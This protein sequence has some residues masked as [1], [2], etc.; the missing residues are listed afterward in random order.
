[1][2]V[3]HATG[4][5]FPDSSGGT[6]V[7]VDALARNLLA[8]GFD[9]SVAAATDGEAT[10]YR[11]NGV[12]VH[13]FPAGEPTRAEIVGALPSPR[14]AEF[15][16]TLRRLKADV[17][18]QHSWSRGCGLAHLR[19][20]KAL[21]LKTVVTVH[22]ATLVC[23]RGTMMLDGASPCDGLVEVA[24]CSECWGPTRGIPRALARWQGQ[25]SK[26]AATLG[27]WLPSASRLRTALLTPALVERRRDD[28]AELGRQADRIVAVCR[29]LYDALARNGV[30]REKLVYCPQGIDVPG[31]V[32]LRARGA[33]RPGAAVRIGF[34]GRCDGAKGIHVLVDAVRRLPAETRVELVIHALPFDAA[35]ARELRDRAG[36]DARIRFA[37]PI[38]RTRLLDELTTFDVLAVPSLALETGPLV[39][40]E[41][42]AAG[43]PVLGSNL[44]G[45]AELVDRERGELLPAGDVEAWSR[46]VA[47]LAV[48]PP[49]VRW[50]SIAPP[51]RSSATIAAEMADVYVQLAL[52][53][54]SC[55]RSA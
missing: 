45:I 13:R 4:W 43:L 12:E 30:P 48:E 9:S 31:G 28:I 44:G 46:A 22:V 17:Y 34:V 6:E 1:M 41:A 27:E 16:T 15:E 8:R 33:E 49:A 39:V 54:H 37:E 47:K 55:C 35:Y 10:T 21:G 14:F 40:L 18:H 24:R 3:V 19:C 5:Y 25:H 42:F 38:D 11:W 51:A 2:N 52:D 26:A 20:A 29:W 7:Y 50:P 53:A 36:A 32:R 23:L